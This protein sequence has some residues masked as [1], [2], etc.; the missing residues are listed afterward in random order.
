MNFAAPSNRALETLKRYFWTEKDKSILIGCDAKMLSEPCDLITLAQSVDDRLSRMQRY[1]LGRC[2][3]PDL[4]VYYF[5]ESHIQLVSY[6]ISI[7][8]IG[9]LLIGAM[10]CLS[11]LNGRKWQI[12]L[13]LVAVSTSLFTL[14]NGLLTNARRAEIFG[15]TAACAA[16]L[17]VYV[18]ANLGPPAP[19]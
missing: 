5:S 12:R 14:F 2:V 17:V 11:V 9:V 1:M 4:D 15:S 6:I 10:A 16:V 13:V 18:S 8:L 19:P 3:R 7:L